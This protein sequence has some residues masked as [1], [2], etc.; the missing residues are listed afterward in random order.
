[1]L[2]ACNQTTGTAMFSINFQN[3]HMTFFHSYFKAPN[4]LQCFSISLV[5]IYFLAVIPSPGKQTNKQTNKKEFTQTLQ[6][7]STGLAQVDERPNCHLAGLYLYYWS[8]IKNQRIL[9][10]ICYKMDLNNSWEWPIGDILCWE[11]L[12]LSEQSPTHQA[13]YYS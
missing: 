8:D 2:K 4:L 10:S 5:D 12:Q 11:I 1:M 7:Y 6:N 3:E 9:R 13:R